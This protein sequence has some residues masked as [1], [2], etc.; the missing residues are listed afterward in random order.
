MATERTSQSGKVQ[1]NSLSTGYPPISLSWLSALTYLR[2][3]PKR[4][5][6]VNVHG[7]CDGQPSTGCGC[8]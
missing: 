8:S 6:V 3:K 5:S 2:T 1:V 4:S 7:H